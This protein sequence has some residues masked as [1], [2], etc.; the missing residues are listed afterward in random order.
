MGRCITWRRGAC[1]C[2]I[3][4]KPT[5]GQRSQTFRFGGRVLGILA[6]LESFCS[7]VFM[8]H[9]LLACLG[10]VVVAGGT[11]FVRSAAIA[12]SGTLVSVQ[13]ISDGDTLRVKMNGKSVRVRFACADLSLP[14]LFL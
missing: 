2:P 13:S 12:Q 10:L 9:F 6:G 8:R 4:G 11:P 3:L 5:R 1:L 7:L 14:T